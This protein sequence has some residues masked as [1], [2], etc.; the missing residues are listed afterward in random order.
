M[1]NLIVVVALLITTA[2]FSQKDINGDWYI[3]GKS[4]F[5]VFS[6]KGDSISIYVD[7]PF[8]SVNTR[9]KKDAGIR[10]T[11][12]EQ[13]G[14]VT[15]FY[16]DEGATGNDK[17]ILTFEPV[18]EKFPVLYMTIVKDSDEK[19][20]PIPF[21]LVSKEEI[22]SYASLKKLSE[23]TKED[24][25]VFAKH[26]IALQEKLDALQSSR[27]TAYMRSEIKYSLIRM[28]YNSLI[29]GRAMKDAF[30]KFKEDPDTKELLEKLGS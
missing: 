5:R 6:I 14:N 30:T 7:I 12:R 25:I 19:L 24:F 8:D 22:N 29:R 20:L 11:R 3:P 23:L 26:I 1:K 10:V 9:T 17:A 18:D 27:E 28:G 16:I 2:G 4:D 15:K 13:V 21:R